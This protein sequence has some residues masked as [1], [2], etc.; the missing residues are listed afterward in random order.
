MLVTSVMYCRPPLITHV[1]SVTLA[2]KFR[3]PSLVVV[4]GFLNCDDL[5]G[6][7]L[8]ASICASMEA[9]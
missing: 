7:T 8:S 3:V 4:N 9:F 6:P 2:V 5:N 1:V